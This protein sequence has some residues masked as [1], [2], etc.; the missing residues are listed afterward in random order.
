[1]DINEPYLIAHLVRG[2]PAFDIAIKIMIGKEEGWV[3]PTSGH[4]AWPYWHTPIKLWKKHEQG[5]TWY[6]DEK[7]IQGTNFVEFHLPLPLPSHPDHYSANNRSQTPLTKLGQRGIVKDTLSL[8]DL[9][10]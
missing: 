4:R 3:I 6:V 7:Q 1:M 2:K 5:E 9:E 10:L 8:D